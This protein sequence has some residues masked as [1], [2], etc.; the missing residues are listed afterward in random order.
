ME[1]RRRIPILLSALL[2]SAPCGWTA[3]AT[4]PP[5]HQAAATEAARYGRADR[6][7]QVP[8]VGLVDQDGRPIALRRLLDVTTPVFLNFIFATCSTVCPVLSAGFAGF[9]RSLGDR[10]AQPLLVSITIDPEHDTPEVLHEYA[11]RFGA[12]EGWVFLTGARGDIDSVMQAFDVYVSNRMEHRPVTLVRRGNSDRWTRI[13]G[14]MSVAD[15][16]R[17][18][19]ALAAH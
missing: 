4:E 2:I 7:Y 5:C 8:D 14:F 16:A 13:E 10:T 19:A 6:A 11:R 18:Y 15:Y 17:E 3:R 12:R 1:R 9:Q